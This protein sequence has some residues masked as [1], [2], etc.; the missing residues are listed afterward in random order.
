M[1]GALWDAGDL[2]K[3]LEAFLRR[4]E[5]RH[6]EHA[7]GEAD[8]HM[9]ASSDEGDS[10]TEPG[11]RSGRAG[12]PDLARLR[13]LSAQLLRCRSC[14]AIPLVPVELL[15]GLLKALHAHL[16]RG[17]DKVLHRREQVHTRLA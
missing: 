17:R 5:R 7:E 14:G 9:S 6:A 16:L 4:Q 12:W 15:Q 3:L 10:D 11:R 1:S 13:Q 2:S 8:A